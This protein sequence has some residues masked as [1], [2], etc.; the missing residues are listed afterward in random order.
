MFSKNAMLIL[1]CN[2]ISFNILTNGYVICFNSFSLSSI[3]C[4]EFQS[5]VYLIKPEL[6]KSAITEPFLLFNKNDMV[7]L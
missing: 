5:M 1:Y 3:D 6:Y 7:L 2:K 4:I